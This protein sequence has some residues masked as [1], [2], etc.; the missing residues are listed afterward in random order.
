MVEKRPLT[1]EVVKK[2]IKIGVACLVVGGCLI[3]YAPSF[4]QDNFQIARNAKSAKEAAELISSNNKKEVMVHM[5]GM[6][7]L[8]AGIAFLGFGAMSK[9]KIK[10]D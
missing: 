4:S 7:C 5:I 2:M 10:K 8:G 9:S 3:A 1:M 6:A